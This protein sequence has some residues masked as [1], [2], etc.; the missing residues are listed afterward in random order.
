MRWHEKGLNELD[1]AKLLKHLLKSGINTFHVSKEYSSYNL[2]KSAVSL[3]PPE[4]KSKIKV[5]LKVP[6][7]NF[8]EDYKKGACLEYLKSF[9]ADCDLKRVFAVQLLDRWDQ[10]N[11]E[12]DLSR[13]AR[14]EENLHL[15]KEEVKLIKVNSLA[16]VIYS[17]PYTVAYAKH[18]IQAN[19]VDGFT[20]YGNSEETD[21]EFL[22]N[23]AVDVIAI[24]PLNAG[25]V[26][27]YLSYGEAI[28]YMADKGYS[29]TIVSIN[30][31]KQAEAILKVL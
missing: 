5:V 27:S 29:G 3:L 6:F 14:L 19:A 31:V 8:R 10:L 21:Y 24:R 9:L 15:L 22:L 18:L 11:G 16:K 20:V 25:K 12:R 30:S 17:F 28:R 1:C 23:E 7:P 2:L 13:I 26:L 4:E